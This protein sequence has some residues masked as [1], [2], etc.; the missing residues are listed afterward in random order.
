MCVG[1]LHF[2]CA[3]VARVLGE[4]CFKVRTTLWIKKLA[5]NWALSNTCHPGLMM[6][7]G[8]HGVARKGSLASK[9]NS[10]IFLWG[11][12]AIAAVQ[13]KIISKVKAF[14]THGGIVKRSVAQ[15]REMMSGNHRIEYNYIQSCGECRKNA[16]SPARRRAIHHRRCGGRYHGDETVLPE[17]HLKWL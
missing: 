7:R 15:F 14:V 6:T 17:S 11:A 1:A 8:G 16:A 4:K 3:V 2:R 5:P 10:C 9:L 12:D 13:K